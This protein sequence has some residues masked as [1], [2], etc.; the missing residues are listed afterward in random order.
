MNLVAALEDLLSEPS[1]CGKSHL[2]AIDGRAGAG[3][4]TLAN[5]LSLALGVDH[6]V[7]LIHLDM[8]YAG[9]EGSLGES[10]T[11]TLS[12]LLSDLSGGRATLLPIF[13]WKEMVFDSE[14]VVS[15]S[16]LIILEGVGS[17]QAAVR[18][19]STATIWL[20]IDPI[21]GL[22]RVLDREGMAFQNQMH[23]WQVAEEAHFLADDTREKADFI[24]STW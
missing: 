13:N 2:I 17:A 18:K 10:L 19:Y 4:T 20:D 15:P 1:R 22:Q 8:V 5:E 23:R 12:Q 9:W 3:K 6:A 24:L 16:G 11:A 21:I 7:T 14:Q